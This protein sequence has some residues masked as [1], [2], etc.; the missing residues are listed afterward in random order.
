M[1]NCWRTKRKLTTI[2]RIY[3]K[4]ILRKYDDTIRYDA[5]NFIHWNVHYLNFLRI[6]IKY[7]LNT[8]IIVIELKRVCKYHC[9]WL[10][11]SMQ[12]NSI[13]LSYEWN[14]MDIVKSTIK[15]GWS[16]E[17]KC[18]KHLHPSLLIV[19]I[20]LTGFIKFIWTTN[21]KWRQI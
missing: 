3:K 19:S 16:I 1:D 8:T 13:R 7:C 21:K 6:T 9:L 17:M 10:W 4:F 15:C 14:M 5:V 18:S 12:L 20:T 11:C 2:E